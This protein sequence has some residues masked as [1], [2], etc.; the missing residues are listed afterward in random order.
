MITGRGGF[1]PTAADSVGDRDRVVNWASRDDLKVSKDGLVV[2]R[3]S[4]ELEILAQSD[5][6]IQQAQGLVIAADGSVWLTTES[7][8]VT[9]ENLGIPHPN[10]HSSFH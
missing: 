6:L 9:T 7:L 2:V 1:I 10:F 4:S 3:K 8:K 5:R